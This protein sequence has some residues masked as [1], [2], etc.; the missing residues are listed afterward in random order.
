MKIKAN[1]ANAKRAHIQTL[2]YLDLRPVLE[3]LEAEVPAAQAREREAHW[4]E[5]HRSPYLLNSTNGGEGVRGK[6]VSVYALR[7]PRSGVVFYVGIAINT[8]ARFRQHVDD[9]LT[10]NAIVD[11]VE[12]QR[13]RWTLAERELIFSGSDTEATARALGRTVGAVR[14]NR[15][16]MISASGCASR[17]VIDALQAAFNM[18]EAGKLKCAPTVRFYPEAPNSNA[19]PIPVHLLAYAQSLQ[20]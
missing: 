5:V 6:P 13:E 15:S 4:I 19:R 9:A 14:S 18:R 7:D 16:L 11:R 3:V 10:I 20:K 1:I 8:A 2:L 17:F 12:R